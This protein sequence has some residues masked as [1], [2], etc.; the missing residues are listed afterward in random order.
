M[1]SPVPHVQRWPPPP[2]LHIGTYASTVKR[3]HRLKVQPRYLNLSPSRRI[4]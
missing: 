3:Y 2:R 4:P 1:V